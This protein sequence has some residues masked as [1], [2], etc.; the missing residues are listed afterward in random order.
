[1]DTCEAPETVVRSQFK[2]LGWLPAVE[3]HKKKHG[4][5]LPS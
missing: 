3:I 5:K 1:M 4:S 2:K